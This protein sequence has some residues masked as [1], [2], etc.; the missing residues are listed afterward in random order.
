M[1]HLLVLL[2]LI[3]QPVLAQDVYN[4]YFQK[5]DHP[6]EM[7]QVKNGEVVSAKPAASAEAAMAVAS[8]E[9]AKTT[10][11]PAAPAVVNS[12]ATTV[13]PAP[14]PL[15]AQKKYWQLEAG[16]GN[17]TDH[18]RRVDTAGTLRLQYNWNK[19]IGAEAQLI[20]GRSDYYDSYT[21]NKNNSL[22]FAGALGIAVEPLHIELF[23][24]DLIDLGVEGGIMTTN[25]QEENV[26]SQQFGVAPYIGGNVMFN[27]SERLSAK[28]DMKLENMNTYYGQ[29]SLGLAYKF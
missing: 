21:G 25:G 11:T 27:I 28:M 12:V 8:P 29:A 18:V 9:A 26:S 22:Y 23:G 16:Y 2:T 14:S 3:A 6:A 13:A 10:A 7:V 24:W 5:A 15:F 1:K 17:F 4:F 19:Y 20:G